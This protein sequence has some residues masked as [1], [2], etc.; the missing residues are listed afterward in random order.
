MWLFGSRV[1]DDVRGGD[2]DPLVEAKQ[3]VGQPVMLAVA[4]GWLKR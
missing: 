1:H 3:P 2:I 4:S